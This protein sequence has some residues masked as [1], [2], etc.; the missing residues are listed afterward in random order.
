MYRFTMK[1]YSIKDNRLLLT[2][3]NIGECQ[4]FIEQKYEKLKE[5]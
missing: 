2:K 1:Y 5:K 3:I 4:Y